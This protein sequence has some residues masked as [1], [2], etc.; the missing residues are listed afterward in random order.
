MAGYKY[1]GLNRG[2]HDGKTGIWYREWAPGARVSA[3]CLDLEPFIHLGMHLEG[4]RLLGGK[5]FL[6]LVCRHCL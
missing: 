3:L 5:D 2:E 1:F 4:P 6:I